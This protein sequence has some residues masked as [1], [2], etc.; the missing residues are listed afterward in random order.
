MNKVAAKKAYKETRR[1]MG[2]YAIKNSA[3][4]KVYVGFSTDVQAMINRHKAELN[5]GSHRNTE[6]MSEWRLFG[7]L[8]FEFGILDELEYDENAQTN[9]VEELRTLHEMWMRKIEETEDLVR[10][11]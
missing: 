4:N 5:F 1:T 2:V 9:S 3:N 6:L 11:L 10:K 7:E 8:S